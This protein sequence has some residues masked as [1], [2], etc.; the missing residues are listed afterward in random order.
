VYVVDALQAAA[1]VPPLVGEAEGAG[2]LDALGVGVGVGLGEGDAGALAVGVGEGEGEAVG[3]GGASFSTRCGGN[4]WGT[5]HV[6]LQAM[7][8]SEPDPLSRRQGV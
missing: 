4:R 8:P 6:H 1:Q 2:E 7:R 5:W 3:D